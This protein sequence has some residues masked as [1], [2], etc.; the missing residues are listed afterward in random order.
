MAYSNSMAN[1]KTKNTK[2]YYAC[3]GDCQRMPVYNLEF[4]DTNPYYYGMG[5]NVT[6]V[7]L[8][9]INGNPNYA[10]NTIVK[11]RMNCKYQNET[12][13]DYTDYF[14]FRVIK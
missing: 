7:T 8:P 6:E 14:Y 11:W 10:N 5:L 3:S 1:L 13:S 2:Y 12:Y 4:I 9:D